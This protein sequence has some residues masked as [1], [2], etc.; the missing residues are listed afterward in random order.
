M[1]HKIILLDSTRQTL[2]AGGYGRIMK[3]S[4]DPAGNQKLPLY[5]S[6]Q[7]KVTWPPIKPE[8]CTVASKKTK[9][10]QMRFFVMKAQEILFIEK[11]PSFFTTLERG[12]L[13]QMLR[14]VIILS[15]LVW[16]QYYYP[17]K[18]CILFL[19]IY[20]AYINLLSIGKKLH[21]FAKLI[22]NVVLVW[23]II[24]QWRG[25]NQKYIPQDE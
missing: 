15:L 7:E 2:R 9:I 13:I 21:C 18:F 12:G 19:L 24:Q 5:S 20:P 3:G 14:T 17:Y 8:V 11:I 1:S 4:K 16:Y 22:Y 10:I 25:I 23:N 6:T